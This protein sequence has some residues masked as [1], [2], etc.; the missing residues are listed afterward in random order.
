MTA[1]DPLVNVTYIRANIILDITA[2][3]L[4]RLIEAREFP[5]PVCS[6]G[7]DRQWRLSDL[8][9]WRDDNKRS[10]WSGPDAGFAE[11]QAAAQKRT[12]ALRQWHAKRREEALAAA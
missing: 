8:L 1:T 5:G 12:E 10:G 11:R 6:L 7:R 4:N 2:P 3:R 9:A